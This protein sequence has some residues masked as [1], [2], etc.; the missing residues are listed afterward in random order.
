MDLSPAITGLLGLG[1]TFLLIPVI[2]RYC[3]GA[4][5]TSGRVDWH[6]TNKGAV[7]RLGGLALA[8]TFVGLELLV[9]LLYPEERAK[10]PGRN[11]IVLCSL[12]M[13]ALGFWDD[14]RPIG[15][16]KKLLLQILIAT[17]V[18]SFGVGIKFFKI[19]FTAYT[20]DL[21]GW[22]VLLTVM[23]LVGMVNL[24]NLIDGVDGL[25]GGISLML[26]VLIA[27][28][29]HQGGN[30]ELLA[31]GMAGALLGFLWFNFP[32]ARIY[33]GDGGAYFLGFQIGLFSI[34]N[35]HK[36]TV[37]AALIAPLFVLALPILDTSLAILRRGLRGLP[38][39]HP[40]R[41]HIHHHLIDMGLSRRKVVISLYA[42][43]LVFLVMGLFAF[44]SR[45]ELVPIL[46]G[47]AVLILLFCA[48]NL[49]F[50]REWFAVGRVLGNSLNMRQDIQYALSLMRW[51]ELEGRRSPSLDCLWKDFVFAAQK[52]GFTFAKLTL[53]DGE[54]V[55]QRTESALAVSQFRYCFQHGPY[56][57]LEVAGGER[58][59]LDA[60]STEGEIPA[61]DLPVEPPADSNTFEIIGELLA[62]GWT[63]AA[64]NWNRGNP[65]PLRFDSGTGAPK[66]ALRRRWLP[67]LSKRP[68]F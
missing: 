63:K 8:A 46:L 41:R 15:A 7:P 4:K 23:W 14:L 67:R 66:A 58:S 37:I 44:W 6:H 38:I 10:T 39:F 34:V 11:G 20:I 49:H 55:W 50:S 51:L 32:P 25:A 45:G 36:G 47:L 65:A 3:S 29:A 1:M 60:V 12:A 57:I 68:Q 48:G 21:G 33:M 43:T 18:C 9:A 5:F 26:M 42:L 2:L 31:S 35:S 17:A 61:L 28:V 53:E 54:R 13:F 59:Q 27:L 30:F 16:K 56:G 52:L 22:G 64:A 24:I 62:E 40:D 19:P